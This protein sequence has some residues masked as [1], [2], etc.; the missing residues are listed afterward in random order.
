MSTRRNVY[1]NSI[2]SVFRFSSRTD[3]HL[4]ERTLVLVVASHVAVAGHLEQTVVDDLLENFRQPRGRHEEL[5][6]GELHFV[7][8]L[9]LRRI[10]TVLVPGTSNMKTAGVNSS[11]SFK[12]RKCADSSRRSRS[13]HCAPTSDSAAE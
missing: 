5:E 6:V 7:D 13:S 4:H 3:E 12:P 11:N 9:T 10:N 8:E 2:C 1:I